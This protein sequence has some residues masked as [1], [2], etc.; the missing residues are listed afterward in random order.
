MQVLNLPGIKLIWDATI[1][2]LAVAVEII[3][4]LLGDAATIK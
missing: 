1:D 2:L 4:H 3:V